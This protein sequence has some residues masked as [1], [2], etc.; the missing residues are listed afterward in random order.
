MAKTKVT[1]TLVTRTTK[2]QIGRTN[3][4]NNVFDAAGEAE[5]TMVGFYTRALNGTFDTVALAAG[6]LK[7]L[8]SFNSQSQAGHAARDAFLKALQSDD[9][10]TEETAEADEETVT[11]DDATE[12]A[13]DES[14]E[15]KVLPLAE[16]AEIICPT[17][18]NPV[19]ALKKRISRG[20]LASFEMEG[21]TFVEMPA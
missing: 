12:A 11:E 15:P 5:T 20:K 8:G 9:A 7:A 17:A 6:T 4:F 13:A 21:E 10:A 14:D 3:I 18:K 19:A 16:A 2:N 1:F